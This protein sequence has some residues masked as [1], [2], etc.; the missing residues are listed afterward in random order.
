MSEFS[1]VYKLFIDKIGEIANA[2]ICQ[3]RYQEEE[4]EKLKESLYLLLSE[5]NSEY[6]E[7]AI[8]FAAMHL[9]PSVRD[10]LLNEMKFFNSLKDAG[11]IDGDNVKSSLEDLLGN[12][13]PDWLMEN[14]KVLNELLS[15]GRS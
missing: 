1:N 15:F 7:L 4:L 6:A 8:D 13:L 2:G 11:S 9:N 12:W 5:T 10:R 14:L 3:R